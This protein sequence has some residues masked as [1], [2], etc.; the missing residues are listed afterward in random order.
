MKW[1]DIV[2][3]PL[4]WIL[5]AIGSVILSVI[6]NLLTP[7]IRALITRRLQSRQSGLGEKQI[8]RRETILTLQANIHRRTATKLDGIF[9]VLVAMSLLLLCLFLFQLTSGLLQTLRWLDVPVLLVIL[10][11]VLV[12]I[13]VGKLG[14]D[15]MSLALTADKREHASDEFLKAHGQASAEEMKQFEDAWDLRE[16]GVNSQNVPLVA[17]H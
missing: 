12:A 17:N 1:Q 16:F 2:T 13:A 11:A 4:F 15:D 14:L 6:A 7:R 9:K 5:S 8:K 3:T 10:L